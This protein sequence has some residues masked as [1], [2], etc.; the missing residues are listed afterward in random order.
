MSMASMESSRIRSQAFKAFLAV[1]SK[2]WEPDEIE[3]FKSY[4]GMDNELEA[5]IVK[6]MKT[7]HYVVQ[8]ALG[9]KVHADEI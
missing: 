3:Y 8:E 5:A 9:K 2:G 1:A 6:A 7:A 4:A